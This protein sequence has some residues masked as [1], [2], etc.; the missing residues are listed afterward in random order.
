MQGK[1]EKPSSGYLTDY[2]VGEKWRKGVKFPVGD[3][4]Y[5]EFY[6]IIVEGITY[7]N[8]E[9]NNADNIILVP[10]EEDVV[11]NSKIGVYGANGTGASEEV[12]LEG[13]AVRPFGGKQDNS[14]TNT[15][16]I[17]EGG[18][19][20]R[21][22]NY[23][24][25][26]AGHEH[27]GLVVSAEDN[28]VALPILVPDGTGIKMYALNDSS[29]RIPV[30]EQDG[31]SQPLQ[32]YVIFHG[33]TSTCIMFRKGDLT[34]FAPGYKLYYEDTYTTAYIG[35]DP[36]HIRF[37]SVGKNIYTEVQL[38]SL[39]NSG[40]DDKL[41]FKGRYNGMHIQEG[42]LPTREY[43]HLEGMELDFQGGSL[44]RAGR[45]LKYDVEFKLKLNFNSFKEVTDKYIP[46]YLING[47]NA[48]RPELGGLAY[49][50]SYNYFGDS[51]GKIDSTEKLFS[52]FDSP[53]NYIDSWAFTS[54]GM[55]VRYEKPKFEVTDGAI[56]ITASKYFLW[57]D[58]E[59]EFMETDLPLL[60]FDWALNI[61]AG[62][63]LL[64]RAPFESINAPGSVAVL[65]YFESEIVE[66]E[67][68]QMNKGTLYIVGSRLEPGQITRDK[69]R[70]AGSK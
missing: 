33:G 23:V 67:G 11:W 24:A 10:E 57:Q 31:E 32:G 8:P 62:H 36:I 52:I 26:V 30:F 18:N 21:Y 22:N 50:T 63:F 35:L 40:Q 2:L 46:G 59:R 65:G 34:T 1:A 49:H 53:T 14:Q 9:R 25:T 55:K 39:T 37:E 3:I 45:G 56:I 60:R 27:G 54:D 41:L 70:V 15:R 68:A 66:E 38:Y 69:I 17:F 42:S 13:T 61:M 58:D 12:F 20:E 51:A 7:Q 19:V 28:S 43:V 4:S 29:K 47:E 44:S 48:I 5:F 16:I 6:D 64:R